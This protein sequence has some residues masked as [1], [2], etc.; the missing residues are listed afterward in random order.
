M[1]LHACRVIIIHGLISRQKGRER[2]LKRLAEIT[3]ALYHIDHHEG[4]LDIIPF[5]RSDKK[6]EIGGG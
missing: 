3:N 4:L 1:L 5:L 2:L 6:E